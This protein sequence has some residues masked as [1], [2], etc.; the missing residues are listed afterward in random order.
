MKQEVPRETQ[1][2][3]NKLGYVVE[4]ISDWRDS[5]GMKGCKFLVSKKSDPKIYSY[6]W[7][8]KEL[9]QVYNFILKK[10]AEEK[11]IK[12]REEI[13]F[14]T[15]ELGTILCKLIDQNCACDC[16]NTQELWHC[17]YAITKEK[18][19]YCTHEASCK[20]HRNMIFHSEKL[21]EMGLPD[22]FI[23][24]SGRHYISIWKTS[25]DGWYSAR[26]M[27]VR[28]EKRY[29]NSLQERKKELKMLK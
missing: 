19:I 14:P 13:G 27:D 21:S 7:D 20:S 5:S 8:E 4:D 25:N 29:Y 3:F 2:R 11:E 17:I 26:R 12:K 6:V 18:F 16:S 28:E 22:N 9:E 10:I 15:D 23:I 24:N 1:E